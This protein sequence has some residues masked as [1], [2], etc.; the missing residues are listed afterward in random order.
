MS[1]HKTTALLLTV[2][3]ILPTPAIALTQSATT[4]ELEI[5]GQ[6][7]TTELE[8]KPLLSE[9]ATETEQIDET[10]SYK[11]GEI[12]IQYDVNPD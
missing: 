7:T 9:T 2:L 6:A 1:T 10:G 5:K 12:L 4:T 11:M 3:I 8:N